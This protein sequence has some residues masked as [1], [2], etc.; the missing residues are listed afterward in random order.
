VSLLISTCSHANFEPGL[1]AT[2][3]AS[4]LLRPTVTLLRNAE[5]EPPSVRAR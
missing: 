5:H 1:P 3:K 2:G 4:A